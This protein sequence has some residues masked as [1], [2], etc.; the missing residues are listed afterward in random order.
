VK[1]PTNAQESSG[2]FINTFQILPRHV[3]AN[4]CYYQGF[5]GALYATQQC[6]VCGRMRIMT[7]PLWSV[8]ECI[9]VYPWVFVG[10]FTT[11]LQD[12]R[13]NYQEIFIE[14]NTGQYYELLLTQFNF[15]LYRTLY[16]PLYMQACVP[17]CAQELFEYLTPCMRNYY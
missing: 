17:S 14:F 15:Y 11:I 7:R 10:N 3:S 12:A 5:V 2:L 8:V 16:G 9:Q 13:S 6:S 1:W 4:G